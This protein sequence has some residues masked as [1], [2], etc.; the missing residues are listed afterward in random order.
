MK[1]RIPFST[2]P[3][4]KA[5]KN[6]AAARESGGLRV[7][8]TVADSRNRHELADTMVRCGLQP[9]PVATVTESRQI[10]AQQPVS[11]V[12]CE[13]MLADGSYREILCEMGS[14]ATKAPVIVISRLADWDRYL[15][16]MRWGA[17]DYLAYPCRPI[18]VESIVGSA[19]HTAPLFP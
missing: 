17:F 11:L 5:L 9:I 16:A 14:I 15:E 19:L 2:N 1:T 8:V 7:L 10:L 4:M 3:E 12:L 18:E 6:P 13:E